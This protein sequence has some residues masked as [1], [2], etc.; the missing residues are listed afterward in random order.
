M[1]PSAGGLHSSVDSDGEEG[2][3][4]LID[5]DM[6]P[7][8]ICFVGWAGRWPLDRPIREWTYNQVLQVACRSWTFPCCL[9]GVKLLASTLLPERVVG[10]TSD[11]WS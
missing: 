9:S 5:V 7:K 6:G 11:S 8:W 1:Y 3:L 10:R 2:V 4:V